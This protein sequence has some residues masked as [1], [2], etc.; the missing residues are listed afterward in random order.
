MQAN[1]P[2]FRDWA[3]AMTMG[4]RKPYMPIPQ[5]HRLGTTWKPWYITM[6]STGTSYPCW[7]SLNVVQ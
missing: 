7:P 6:A 5:L 2:Q 1:N 3:L 4:R